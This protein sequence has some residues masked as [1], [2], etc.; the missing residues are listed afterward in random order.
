MLVPAVVFVMAAA[1]TYVGVTQLR[2]SA[3][4]QTPTS[5]DTIAGIGG[6]REGDVVDMPELRTLKGERAG[7]QWAGQMCRQSGDADTDAEQQ[8]LH[9]PDHEG[10]KQHHAPTIAAVAGRSPSGRVEFFL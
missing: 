7:D 10:A 8:H 5:D 2:P 9:G 6:L 3:E 4:Q 1:L